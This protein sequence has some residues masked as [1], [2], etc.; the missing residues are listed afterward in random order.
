MRPPQTDE[1]TRWLAVVGWEDMQ[2]RVAALWFSYPETLARPSTRVDEREQKTKSRLFQL[3]KKLR[4]RDH[5]ER[6]VLVPG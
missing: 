6:R 1:S 5:D 2:L 3:T 4:C